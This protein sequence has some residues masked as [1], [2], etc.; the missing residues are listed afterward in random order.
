MILDIWPDVY[1]ELYGSTITGLYI[2]NS[3]IDFEVQRIFDPA[4]LKKLQAKLLSSNFAEP[5][6]VVLLDRPLFP[7]ITFID[8]ESQIRIDIACSTKTRPNQSSYIK[9][10]IQKYP[11]LPKVYLVLKQFL[12][13]RKLNSSN[14]GIKLRFLD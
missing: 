9:K 11:D 2:P 7:L 13:Q 1:V 5:N 8:R 12:K 4:P 14:T 3:D 6:T 10:H